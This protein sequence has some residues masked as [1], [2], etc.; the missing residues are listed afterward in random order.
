MGPT[1]WAAYAHEVYLPSAWDS[2]RGV[3]TLAGYLGDAPGL[4]ETTRASLTPTAIYH[5]VGESAA[6]VNPTLANLVGSPDFNETLARG[7]AASAAADMGDGNEALRLL[8]DMSNAAIEANAEGP[9]VWDDT[10][11]SSTAG[12]DTLDSRRRRHRSIRCRPSRGSCSTGIL[13]P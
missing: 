11:F 7:I 5:T 6:L 1:T 13:R 2:T 10:Y 4:G 3:E 9:D 8:H 12:D